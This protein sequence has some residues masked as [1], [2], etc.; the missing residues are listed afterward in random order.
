MEDYSLQGGILFRDFKEVFPKM[1][2]KNMLKGFEKWI[3]KK[4]ANASDDVC[5]LQMNNGIDKV[6]KLCHLYQS[7]Q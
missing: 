7:Y 6:V 1:L 5:R 3:G 4:N 2:Q